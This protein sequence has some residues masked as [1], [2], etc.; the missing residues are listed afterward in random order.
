MHT[1]MHTEQAVAKQFSA[2]EKFTHLSSIL[3]SLCTAQGNFM[4]P[5]LCS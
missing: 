3:Q 4:Y 5:D 1:S 2:R